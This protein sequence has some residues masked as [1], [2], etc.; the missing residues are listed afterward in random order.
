MS[1]SPPNNGMHPTRIQRTFYPQRPSA[2]VMPGVMRE[3]RMSEDRRTVHCETHGD[4]LETFICNHV[5]QSLDT[6][7]PV[8]F[9][10]AEDPGNFR[11]DAWCTACNDVL[12]EEGGQWNERSESVADLRLLCGKC[13]DR[14][15]E[16]NFPEW[17][18]F[19]G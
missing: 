10:W 19:F 6:S 14:A 1:T 4:Q 12:R 7:T 17:R 15:R 2:R 8:G 3:F 11:P 9:W 18:K 5:V 13:Y 16:L